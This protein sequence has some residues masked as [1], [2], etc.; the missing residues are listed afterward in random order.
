VLG[1]H[2]PRRYSQELRG[3]LSALRARLGPRCAILVCAMPPMELFPAV[4]SLWPLSALVGT[5]AAAISSVT[6]TTCEMSGLAA[7][8]GWSEALASVNL[9]RD[10]VRRMM[11]PDGFHPARG[12][13]EMMAAPIAAAARRAL[14]AFANDGSGGRNGGGCG[15]CGGADTTD[16]D[17]LFTPGSLPVQAFGVFDGAERYE[18]EGAAPSAIHVV[19]SL[20]GEVPCL[21][22]RSAVLLSRAWMRSD[23]VGLPCASGARVLELGAGLGVCSMTLAALG[24]RQVLATD[25]EPALSALSASLERNRHLGL[26]AVRAL[27][28]RWGPRSSTTTAAAAAAAAA[29]GAAQDGDNGSG[30]FGTVFDIVLCADLIYSRDLHAPLLETLRRFVTPGVT[31]VILTSEGR[32]NE[33][34]FLNAASRELKL[35]GER[36]L[37][38]DDDGFEVHCLRIGGEQQSLAPAKTSRARNGSVSH[39]QSGTLP[40][41]ALS[42]SCRL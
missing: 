37:G 30:V 24:A 16:D 33:V 21:L 39:S 1:L 27:E 9:S 7:C 13:C 3:L 42:P 8:V 20:G 12:A 38:P 2:T 32:G 6:S 19:Q 28:L 23:C 29:A 41:P 18:L 22:W 25:I 35:R 31:A 34:A 17:Y 36:I 15:S 14:Q 26:E 40:G 5:Y 4:S 10:T 11:A